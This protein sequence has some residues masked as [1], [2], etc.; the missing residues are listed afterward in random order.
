MQIS[1]TKADRV[2]TNQERILLLMVCA[3]LLESEVFNMTFEIIR[4]IMIMVEVS[5]K[6]DLD[7]YQI[8]IY[9]QKP[10]SKVKIILYKNIPDCFNCIVHGFEIDLDN[11]IILIRSEVVND[12]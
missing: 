7:D 8:V 12:E 5:T 10:L 3:L 1:E 2:P 6:S 9:S 4:L 11:K